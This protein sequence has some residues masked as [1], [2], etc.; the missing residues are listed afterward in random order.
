[1]NTLMTQLGYTHYVLQKNTNELTHE[2]SLSQP[3]P[4][5]NCLN[6]VM[7][8]IMASRNGLLELLGEEPIWTKEQTDRYQRGG[9]PVTDGSDAVSF[10]QMKKD[11]DASQERIMNG[12]KRFDPERLGEPAPWSPVG[13]ENETYGSLLAGI[14]FHE[15]YH[16]GQTGVLRRVMGKEG[17]IT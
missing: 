16:A 3:Q 12:L 7:G 13:N 6:W 4:G 2:D 1:M 17:A 5:G 9:K 10:D 8:H 14:L 15:A 11:L